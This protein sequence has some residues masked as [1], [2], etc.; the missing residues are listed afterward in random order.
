MIQILPELKEL[1]SHLKFTKIAFTKC[2]FRHILAYINGL[3]ALNRKSIKSITKNSCNEKDHNAIQKLLQKGKF[4]QEKLE[5][6]YL[7]KLKFLFKNLKVNLIFDDTLHQRFGK[8]I[9]GTQLHKDHCT[10]GFINGHQYFTAILVAGNLQ[11]PLF[12]RLYDKDSITKIEMAF[13]LIKNISKK[14][15]ISNVLCDSWYSDV[16]I[17]KLCRKNKIRIICGIK[18]NRK[19]QL[20]F[21]QK[22]TSL[23][24]FSKE[25]SPEKEFWIDDKKYKLESYKTNLKKFSKVNMIISKEF[26]N[27][28][29]SNNFHIISSVQTDDIIKIIRIYNRRWIIETFHRDI[30]QNLGF[31]KCFLRNKISIV[32]HSILVSMAYVALK[33]F[34]LSNKLDMTIGECIEYI[35]HNEFNNFM[36]EIIKIENSE[37]R[38][39]EYTRL[40][41][42][43]TAQV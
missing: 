4:D 3:I 39:A 6:R 26:L 22:Y 19:I 34:M 30:K 13:E 11:F 32:R 28:K 33:L 1:N 36:Q 43:K 27:E 10:N 35:T 9:E 23:A 5:K 20:K 37:E 14:I 8:K 29:W 42:R 24:K 2:G 21:R 18:T 12:P 17:M 16:K 7:K 15:K 40:F 31:N 38:I 25:N 41:I